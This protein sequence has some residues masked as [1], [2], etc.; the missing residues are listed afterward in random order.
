MFQ[1]IEEFGWDRE[2]RAYY[3]MDDDRLYRRTEPPLPALPKA[4]PKAT[5]LKAKAARRRASK[6]AR[7]EDSATPEVTGEPEEQEV[8]EN[9]AD[10]P[11]GTPSGPDVDTLGGYKWEC[12]A[13]TLQE[14]Q[15][16]IASFAKTKDPN[17]KDLRDRLTSDVLPIIEAAQ[18]RQRRKMEA[19]ERNFRAQEKML[20]AKRS[21]RL[22]DK[23]ERERAQREEEEKAAAEEKILAQ[24]RRRE[25]EEAEMADS[26]RTRIMTRDQR[27]QERQYKKLE[28][29][30]EKARAAAEE[31]A[32]ANGESKGSARQAKERMARAK[33]QL[34]EIENDNEDDWTFDCSKCGVHGLNI[35]DGSHSISCEKCSV[36][37]H[38]K[39]LGISEADAEDEN[40]HFICDDCKRKEEEANRPR[41]QLKFKMGQS[42]SSP[43]QP[44]P[45]KE[46]PRKSNFV[47]VEVPQ[48]FRHAQ[49]HSPQPSG[50]GIYGPSPPRVGQNG[51]VATFPSPNPATQRAYPYVISPYQATGS[52]PPPVSQPGYP[53]LQPT[54]RWGPPPPPQAPPLSMSNGTYTQAPPP[55]QYHVS[56]QMDRPMSSGGTPRPPSSDGQVNGNGTPAARLP[57]PI[58]NR[59]IISPS[60]GNYDVSA[61]AGLPPYDDPSQPPRSTMANGTPVMQTSNSFSSPPLS[62]VSPSKNPPPSQSQQ[63]PATVGSISPLP[64]PSAVPI[65]LAATTPLQAAPVNQQPRSVSGTPIFPPAEKLAPSPGHALHGPVPTPSKQATPIGT[66]RTSFEDTTGTALSVNGHSINTAPNSTPTS[67]NQN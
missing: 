52:S 47:A 61:V 5:S 23:S 11:V 19:R 58:I 1:R 37:Q 57:S 6:R 42:S 45:A 8:I 28:A 15:D 9:G 18:E 54:Q 60:Q 67:Q 16:L 32:I 3:L 26:R 62:G 21:S 66:P 36:W 25:A 59:P 33:Q 24:G 27:V 63:P 4:K 17:E 44:S 65:K 31:E 13:I 2:D 41:I 43:P 39:C 46:S 49:A 64:P 14:Y 30:A 40:F 20:H 50:R 51:T 7:I 56:A 34:E 53:P 22:A 48:D 29:E 55:Q 35:D 10:D 12:I 38:S